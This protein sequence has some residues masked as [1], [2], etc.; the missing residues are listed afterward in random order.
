MEINP[1]EWHPRHQLQ[2]VLVDMHMDPDGAVTIVVTGRSNT[3]RADLWRHAETIAPGEHHLVASDVAHH[4]L[5]V[6]LQDR[7]RTAQAFQDGL[8]GEGWQDVPLPF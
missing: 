3:Q 8:V 7:P 6:A 1:R 2:R 4:M 5:V